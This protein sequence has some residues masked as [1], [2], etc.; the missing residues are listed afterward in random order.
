MKAPALLVIGILL[1]P[2]AVSAQED[3]DDWI[4]LSVFEFEALGDYIVSPESPGSDVS[5]SLSERTR[6]VLDGKVFFAI[7]RPD[8][9][10]LYRTRGDSF[11][12]LIAAEPGDFEVLRP[13][14]KREEFQELTAHLERVGP[15]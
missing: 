3:V 9:T 12:R 10:W 2:A 13:L 11:M 5:D 7:L 14:L 1:L 6:S 4:A 15:I 8:G